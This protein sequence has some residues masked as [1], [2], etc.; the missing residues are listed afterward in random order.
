MAPTLEKRLSAPNLSSRAISWSTENHKG[1]D[2]FRA[3]SCII[4]NGPHQSQFQSWVK[5]HDRRLLRAGNAGIRCGEE[6][7]GSQHIVNSCDD[8]TADQNV[9]ELPLP[10]T[11]CGDSSPGNHRRSGTKLE[12]WA[13]EM[14]GARLGV[15]V[16]GA[17]YQLEDVFSFCSRGV[18][19]EAAFDLESWREVGGQW[20]S[21]EGMDED[22]DRMEGLDI[23]ADAE[24]WDSYQFETVWY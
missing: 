16:D 2:P 21:V 9:Y 6:G 17:V 1:A 11:A 14:F 23:D 10:S 24:D 19:C 13:L 12:P 20:R 4:P 3:D 15:P 8:P 18:P 5:E 7:G 22:G